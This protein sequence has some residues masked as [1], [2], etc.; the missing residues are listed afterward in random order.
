MKTTFKNVL[1]TF[2]HSYVSSDNN[3]I[4][5]LE[6]DVDRITKN[7]M[8][9]IHPTTTTLHRKKKHWIPLLIAAVLTTAAIG[10]TV[11][12]VNGGLSGQFSEIVSGQTDAVNRYDGGNFHFDTSDSNLSARLLGVTGDEHTVLA[13]VA[14]S[15]QDGRSFLDD[16]EGILESPPEPYFFEPEESLYRFPSGGIAVLP[17]ATDTNIDGLEKIS[18]QDLPCGLK[19]VQADGSDLMAAQQT[20]YL[21]SDDHKT[22]TIYFSLD[23][24]NANAAI[25]GTLTF[26]SNYLTLYQRADKI[27]AYDT[28]DTAIM[29]DAE[30]V[31]QTQGITAPTLWEQEN[32]RY[33]LYT[34]TTQRHPLPFTLSFQMNYAI[35]NHALSIELTK[36]NA[37]HTITDNRHAAITLSPFSVQLKGD[38]IILADHADKS[39]AHL[40]QELLTTEDIFTIS[41]QNS[42]IVL[43][44]GTVYYFGFHLNNLNARM[45]EDGTTTAF[46][47]VTGDTCYTDQP[48]NYYDLIHNP[49]MESAC[50]DHLRF[51]R[52]LITDPQNIALVIV[53]GDTVY[54]AAPSSAS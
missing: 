47:D 10:T 33:T 18:R 8:E 2:E 48:I 46:V 9:R 30:D 1:D 44:D 52:R 53:N 34:Y 24:E 19:A 27:A 16:G 5:P 23:V 17:D 50:F 29:Q 26:A 39:I 3:V 36:D 22:L 11:V 40:R 51:M 49:S 31:C 42:K 28:L 37:P 45:E 41:E 21:L 4:E 43:K 25:D 38:P 20:A 15:Y 6:L 32:G 7:V 12:A 14:L 54:R 13:G 35:T